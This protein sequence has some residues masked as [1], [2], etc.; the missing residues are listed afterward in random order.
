MIKMISILHFSVLGQSKFRTRLKYSFFQPRKGFFCL[1][2]ALFLTP[3]SY[4]EIVLQDDAGTRFELKQPVKRIV[5]LAPFITELLFEIGSENTVSGTLEFSD[6]PPAA[7]E[8]PRVGRHNA[9]DVEAILAMKPD[10]LIAWKTGTPAAPLEQLKRMGLPVFY[11]EPIRLRDI[12]RSLEKLGRLTG[13]VES[14][15]YQAM[16][17]DRQLQKLKKTYRG[18]QKLNVFYQIWDQPLMSVNGQHL[19]SDVLDLC[20]GTNIFGKVKTV[21]FAV[22]REA[23]I[24]AN[25]DV[26]VISGQG[27]LGSNW[28]AGWK[29]WKSITAVKY[30]NLFQVNPDY[31]RHTS[32][33]L[34][35]ARQICKAL[36]KARL[37]LQK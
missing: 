37:H 15:R 21:S 31:L 11:L 9:L 1:F 5:S 25:P 30:E 16:E 2:L 36:E 20:G 18:K 35:G 8:I 34:L 19:V 28:Q 6:Y 22:N 12:S 23:V 24:A 32:R 29:K 17:F 7:R 10:L 14:A 27:S 3:A 26:I 13:R 4:A 33:V